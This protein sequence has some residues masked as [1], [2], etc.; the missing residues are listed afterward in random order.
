LLDLLKQLAILLSKLDQFFFHCHAFTLLD[1]IGFGKPLEDLTSYEKSIVRIKERGKR[2]E[3]T[4]I[5][6]GTHCGGLDTRRDGGK[7]RGVAQHH[8]RLGK[9]ES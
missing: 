1:A 4:K 2:I 8:E 9:R 7:N 5:S 6:I 3:T